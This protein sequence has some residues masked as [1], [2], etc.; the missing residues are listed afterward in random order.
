MATMLKARG[1]VTYKNEL[2]VPEGAMDVA[3]N[4]VIDEDGVAQSRRGFSEYGDALPLASDRAS[5]LLE[6]K[7]RVLLHYNDV[8]EFDDG[9]GTFTAFNGTFSALEAGLRIKGKEINGNFYFTTSDGVKKISAL[10]ASQFT[11]NSG[12]ITKAG[13]AK[14]LD[15]EGTSTGSAGFLPPQSKAAYRIVWGI[16]DVNNNLILGSPSSH[17]VFTNSNTNTKEQATFTF[18]SDVTNSEY[19]LLST[20]NNEYVFWF[21]VTGS[22]TIPNNA[23]TFG[24]VHIEVDVSGSGAANDA[25]AFANAVST[26]T[27]NGVEAFTSVA[28]SST[29][30]QVTATVGGAVLSAFAVGTGT[31][32]IA[33]SATTTGAA[34]TSVDVSIS[35]QVPED[36][37]NTN[38]FYQ[39]YRSPYVTVDEGLTTL[40]DI[41]PSDELQLV[42]EA[43]ITNAEISAGTITFTD[44]TP[45]DFRS[46]GTYL[47]SNQING[48]GILQSNDRPPICKDIDLFRGSTFYA[49]TKSSHKLSLNLLSATGLN[50]YSLIL[51]NSAGIKRTYTFVN[52]GPEQTT[53]VGGDIDV[54]TTGSVSQNIDA[55]ARSLA[56]IINKDASSPVYAY[57]LSTSSDLPGQILLENRSLADTEFFLSVDN[58]AIEGKFSPEIAT[59]FSTKTHTSGT[60]SVTITT[61][62]HDFSVG[63]LVL[64]DNATYITT[65]TYSVTATTA[66]TITVDAT[67]STTGNVDVYA[68]TVNSDNE[69]FSNRIYYSKTDQPDAVPSINYIDIGPRDQEIKRII[70]LRDN[71]IVLKE[72]GIY[73]ITGTSAPNFVARNLDNS[74]FITAPD[75]AA[76]LNNKIYALTNQGVAQITGTGVRIISRPIEDKILG[77]S[78]P[79]YAYKTISFGIASENDRSYLIWLP[80]STS[81]TVATQAFRY[82]VFTNSWTRWTVT[83]TAGLVSEFDDKIYIGAGDENRL[84]KER[85]NFDRTDYADRE[86]LAAIATS[87]VNGNLVELN[88]ALGISAGDVMYQLQYVTIAQVNRTIQKLDRDPVLAIS[89]AAGGAGYV[90]TVGLMVAGDSLQ[91]KLQN[92][93]DTINSDANIGTYSSI[94]FSAEFS[95]IQTEFNSMIAQLNSSSTGTFYKNYSDSTGTTFYEAVITDINSFTRIATL[96][97]EIPLIFGTSNFLTIYKGIPTEI[98]WT[99]QHFGQPDAMKQIAEGSIIF[100]QNNFY[101][102]ELSYRSDI[103]RNFDEVT[104]YGSGI[105]VWGFSSWG[106]T[107]WGGEGSDIPFRTY[108]P[109]E[110]QRCRYLTV[111]FYHINARET[112]KLIG[113]SM[114]PRL[115]SNRAYR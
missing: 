9:S 15:I 26:V 34:G 31:T 101:S 64:L 35:T 23:E 58:A 75:S 57:Y 67:A 60:G 111:R 25:N 32:N 2:E 44:E 53:T 6:Y 71:L 4:I 7:D 85:K 8:L 93:N 70:A 88:S 72:D 97:I 92:L 56:R 16:K 27:E 29:Q 74:S 115:I 10:N 59:L 40:D 50:T 108:V 80:T 73:Y 87:G 28:A 54:Q 62:T 11:S 86:F 20:I 37:T 21:N 30:I 46:S 94:T 109:L 24:K 51:I 112:Y 91:L 42:Y 100:D 5:Q 66:T 107:T 48:E 47:Y 105:G 61:G 45:D 102:A 41:A 52:G 3:D 18:S 84:E 43:N 63:D 65:G 69:V 77:V 95:T 106:A 90:N 113:I 33:T 114:N 78:N 22:D 96:N 79:R 81:D 1:L 39:L 14:G 12:Y 99:P 55:T 38:Y 17:Y 98:I 103:S 83:A 36:I 82:N 19:V 13:V 104:F 68:T 76:V 49:N 89:A 110:K